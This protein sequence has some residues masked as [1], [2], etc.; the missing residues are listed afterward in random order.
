MEPREVYALLEGDAQR[1][2]RLATLFAWGVWMV[3]MCMPFLKPP[4]AWRN[5]RLF[6]RANTPPGFIPPR[7]RE[8]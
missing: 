4:D 3:V 7:K 2:S 1:F 8:G 5:F 6:L